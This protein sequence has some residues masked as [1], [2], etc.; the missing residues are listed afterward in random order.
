[1]PRVMRLGP[2]RALLRRA[3]ASPWF[4]RRF[5][6]KQFERPLSQ[7]MSAAFFDGYARCSALADLFA[8]LTPALLRQLETQFATRPRALQRIG[9]WW[10][11]RDGVV[12]LLELVW[13]EQALGVRWPGRA[14]PAWGHYPM[15][16]EPEEWVR[17]LSDVLAAPESIP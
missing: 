12:S 8:W 1:M 5:V 16:D 17:A 3:F 14:F 6:R 15:I 4:Q 11:K 2:A 13:T 7:Q 10:G 9:V